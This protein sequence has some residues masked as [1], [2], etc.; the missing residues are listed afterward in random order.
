MLAHEIPRIN[1]QAA[2]PL[3]RLCLY[4]D[5]MNTHSPGT[6]QTADRRQSRR[7]QALRENLKKRKAQQAA[8]G[9]AARDGVEDGDEREDRDE[10]KDRTE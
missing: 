8:R 3:S 4:K 1:C 9:D 6:G 7:A 5:I 2:L 10:R